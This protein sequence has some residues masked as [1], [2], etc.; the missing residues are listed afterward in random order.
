MMVSDRV[1]LLRVFA[2]QARTDNSSFVGRV[3]QH[4]DFEQ[5][6]RIVDGRGGLQQPFHDVALVIN[7]KLNRYPRQLLEFL[8][9]LGGLVPVL[10]VEIG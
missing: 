3:V 8:L 1:T 2:D 6:A 5:R 9:G 4:L 10:Q 7:G